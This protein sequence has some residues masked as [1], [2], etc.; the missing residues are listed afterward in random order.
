MQWE[1][2]NVLVKALYSV[3]QSKLYCGGLI[4]IILRIYHCSESNY[5][6]NFAQSVTGGGGAVS[7]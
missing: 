4:I 2:I 3:E 7:L 5:Y 1:I 6:K